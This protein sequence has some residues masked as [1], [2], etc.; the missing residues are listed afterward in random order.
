MKKI[1][2]KKAEA[3]SVEYYILYPENAVEYKNLQSKGDRNSLNSMKKKTS[4][5]KLLRGK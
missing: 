4:N 2:I 1:S 5:K 3:E